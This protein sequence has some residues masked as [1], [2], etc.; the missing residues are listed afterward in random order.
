[1]SLKEVLNYQI[2][3]SYS[4]IQ[5]ENLKTSLDFI[6]RDKRLSIELNHDE[7]IIR[8]NNLNLAVKIKNSLGEN[9]N[10]KGRIRIYRLNKIK[11]NQNSFK[12]PNDALLVYNKYHRGSTVKVSTSKWRAG[13]Y[14]LVYSINQTE[15]RTSIFNIID[16]KKINL[17]SLS[18][19]V[20]VSN[21][22]S[23]NKL[24]I[25][26]GSSFSDVD[27]WIEFRNR[28]GQK[29]SYIRLDQK[30]RR[31]EFNSNLLSGY[32]EVVLFF[33][34]NN[35]LYQSRSKLFEEDKN[36]TEI[37]RPNQEF[38]IP[39]NDKTIEVLSNFIPAQKQ[40]N[41]LNESYLNWSE[42]INSN[43]MTLMQARILQTN[44]FD[45]FTWLPYQP[46]KQ[47]Y[48]QNHEALDEFAKEKVFPVFNY[49]NR[50]KINNTEK[51]KAP[52]ESNKWIMQIIELE[53][54]GFNFYNEISFETKKEIEIKL[55]DKLKMFSGD[56]IQIP[57]DL[58]NQSDKQL[59]MTAIL[60]VYDK[61]Q[62][63]I[64]HQ[65]KEIQIKKNQS[66]IVNW[67]LMLVSNE[68][69]FSYH[70]EILGSGFRRRKIWSDSTIQT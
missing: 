47:D 16:K 3:A 19:V 18:E 60:K 40:H 1:M 13:Q 59:K 50:F 12:P 17:S 10:P 26:A 46:Y 35:K 69:N 4:V 9:E 34:K 24:E 62:E 31:L 51:M 2:Q 55:V 52:I 22:K 41:S 66:N 7:T 44:R 23:D 53:R 20:L 36:D 28:F 68:S 33:L 5:S 48:R 49:I 54:K 65:V 6:L 38:E 45:Q 39:V 63:I 64:H 42:P 70:L 21:Q 15:F 25:Y 27:A 14:Y 43:E 29:R 67:P 11:A 56:K 37:L 58:K 57:V 8:K 30:L 61:E 32:N